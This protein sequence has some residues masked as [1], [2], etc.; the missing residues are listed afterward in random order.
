MLVQV[1]VEGTLVTAVTIPR[2]KPGGDMKTVRRETV[3]TL[4]DIIEANALVAEEK[5]QDPM[6]M[7]IPVRRTGQ[8]LKVVKGG[9]Q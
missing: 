7:L 5:E 3:R 6:L 9:G 4:T 8:H 2:I 1:N